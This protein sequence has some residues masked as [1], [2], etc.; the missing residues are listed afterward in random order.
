MV[1]ALWLGQAAGA[2]ER[3]SVDWMGNTV[4][5]LTEDWEGDRTQGEGPPATPTGPRN[6]ERHFSK[7]Q[8]T[9][10]CHGGQ[11][12]NIDITTLWFFSKV[13]IY[14]RTGAE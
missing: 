12:L 9:A 1:F 8:E 5:S 11:V 10:H 7:N 13:P 6:T 4:P 3:D 2:L 14:S